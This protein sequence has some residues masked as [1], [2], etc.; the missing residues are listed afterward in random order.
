MSQ[1]RSRHLTLLLRFPKIDR[2]KIINSCGVNKQILIR[3]DISYSFKYGNPYMG[4]IAFMTIVG[5]PI[6]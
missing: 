5:D 4:T 6:F 3:I 2:I 1:F